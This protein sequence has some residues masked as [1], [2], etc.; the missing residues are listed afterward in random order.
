M[1]LHYRNKKEKK[2]KSWNPED[3][4]NHL[5]PDCLSEAC[6]STSNPNLFSY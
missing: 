3:N 6:V 5:F 1:I 4:S 2:K